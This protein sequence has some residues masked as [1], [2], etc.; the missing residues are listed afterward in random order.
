MIPKQKMALKRLIVEGK[1]QTM[2][3]LFKHIP[4]DEIISNMGRMG[5]RV[6]ICLR[7]PGKWRIGEIHELSQVLGMDPDI[8]FILIDNELAIWE[9]KPQ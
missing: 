8:I 2:T 7:N 4:V 9:K 1:I 6:P 3:A 5:K